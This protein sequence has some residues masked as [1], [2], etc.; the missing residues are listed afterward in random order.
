MRFFSK[1][2]KLTNKI[3]WKNDFEKL[4]GIKHVSLLLSLKKKL[5]TYIVNILFITKI[6]KF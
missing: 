5:N 6:K 3:I 2:K 4:K 1:R